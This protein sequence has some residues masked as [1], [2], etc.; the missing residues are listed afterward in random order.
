MRTD[1]VAAVN[2]LTARWL[3]A[4]G[5][6]AL[7]VSGLGVWP[8]LA[9]IAEPSEGPGRAEL[10][11]ALGVA[12]EE[13]MADARAV[14][15]LVNACPAAAMAGGLWTRSG[16]ELEPGWVQRLPEGT[17]GRIT[18]APL[19]DAPV[20]DGWAEKHTAGRITK[21]PITTTP[22]T[23]LVLATALS[24]ETT[25]EQ[26][27]DETV[28]SIPSGGPWPEGE[29]AALSRSSHE[30]EHVRVVP[31]PH[32]AFTDVTV[33]GDRGVDVHLVLGPAEAEPGAV[34]AAGVAAVAP[35][36]EDAATPGTA[37]TADEPHPGP[38][39]TV[40]RARAYHPADEL[41]LR[42]VPFEVTAA[43]DLLE[44]AEVFGLRSVSDLRRGHFPGISR[45]RLG[46]GAAAQNILARFSATGFEAAAVTA[47]GVFGTSVLSRAH[48]VT[49]VSVSF[50]RPFAYYAVDR[51]SGLILV[52]GWLGELTGPAR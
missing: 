22:D 31:T 21:F 25:W 14:L 30:L 44:H 37:F 28:L 16:L 7:V 12:P 50:D 33:V 18:G 52:A 10:A 42:T 47:L 41:R 23:R 5:P 4:A 45:E 6:R 51:G 8:L 26:P 32:G 29:T 15:E 36:A 20:L 9:L 39:I 11:A 49:R 17:R 19:I 3:A 13:S 40:E 43:H 2:A 48:E 46:V 35:A 24:V 27:F 34:L 1:L 38:G